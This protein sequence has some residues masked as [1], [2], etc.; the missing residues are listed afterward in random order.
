MSQSFFGYEKGAFTDAKTRKIG[1]LEEASG[2]TLFLD[3]IGEM[4]MSLQVKL[5]RVIED[6]KFRRLG[7]TRNIDIDVRIIAATNRDL[8]KSNR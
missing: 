2:G 7:N 4:D 6:R 1:L 8:K 5:L 3:E